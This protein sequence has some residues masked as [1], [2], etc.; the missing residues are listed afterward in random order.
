MW[1][2]NLKKLKNIIIDS[3]FRKL[4]SRDFM[5]SI[6][7][8]TFRTTLK[9][10]GQIHQRKIFLLV[11]LSRTYK[12]SKVYRHLYHVRHCLVGK[13]LTSS[14]MKFT[15][16]VEAFLLYITMHLVF[17]TYTCTCSF[18]EVFFKNWLILTLFAPHQRGKKPE[19]HNLCPPCLKDALYK[20]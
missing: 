13:T 19:I 3:T 10:V 9:N 18:R 4:V 5:T 8:A 2:S 7:K 17:L 6:K 1:L 11:A 20:T 14:I 15:T 12:C 16:L